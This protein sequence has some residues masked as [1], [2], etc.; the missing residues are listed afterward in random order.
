M[1][2]R[3][4][5]CL[6]SGG[7]RRRG[8]SVQKNPSLSTLRRHPSPSSALIGASLGALSVSGVYIDGFFQAVRTLADLH[9][10]VPNSAVVLSPLPN[11]FETLSLHTSIF[12]TDSPTCA[13]GLSLSVFLFVWEVGYGSSSGQR[14]FAS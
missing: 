7:S 4:V 5:P 9:L 2:R 10:H 3:K 6:R 12:V 11:G 13:F 14:S 1:A 8:S